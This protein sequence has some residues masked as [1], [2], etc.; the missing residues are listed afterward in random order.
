MVELKKKGMPIGVSDFKSVFENNY[1]YV[2]KTKLIE[3]ITK[4]FSKTIL[5]TRPRR[6]GKTLTMSMLRYFFD[7]KEAEENR[8]LFEGLYI[9]KSEAF[10]Y[11]GQHPVIYLTMKDFKS[12][13]WE[14]MF[15]DIKEELLSLYAANKFSR[16]N[17]DEEKKIIFDEILQRKEGGSF[18]K[19][20]RVLSEALYKHYKKKVVLLIDEYDTPILTAYEHGYYNEAVNFFRTF[21]SAALKDNEYLQLGAMT[22]ILRIAKEGMFSGL[23]N[24]KV[25]TILNKDYS[26]YFGLT[27][28]EVEEMLKYYE[29]EYKIEEVKDWYNGYRFGESEIYNPWS[30]LNYVDEKELKPYWINTSDNALIYELLG[31]ADDRLFND[32]KK[33]FEGKEI[34]KALSPNFS[35]KN[36]KSINELWQLFLHGGYLKVEEKLENNFYKLKL[37]NKEIHSSF[38]IDFVDYILGGIDLFSEMIVALKQGNVFMFERKLRFILKTN[39]SYYD[40]GQEEKYYHNFVLGMV[41]SMM[42]EY[43]I[44]SNFEAGYGRHDITIEPFDKNRMGYVFEFKVAK[45]EEKFDEKLVEGLK[46][47]KDKEYYAGLRANGVKNILALAVAFCGKKVKVLAEALQESG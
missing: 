29:M 2:D 10:A 5:F 19:A 3:E 37:A 27:E 35:F 17:L 34:K 45:S 22:G 44:Q 36:I 4:E 41:L 25:N 21:Y 9:E 23:N 31:N 14:E 24:L 40:G 20:L 46:Q 1:Y 13:S 33:L 15:R 42:K 30:I 8:K 6:F 32:L 39:V 26:S 16:E 12:R 18:G 28:A 47:I 11:Q 43:K 7:I 38:K